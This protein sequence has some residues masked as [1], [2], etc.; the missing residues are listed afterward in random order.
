M[1]TILNIDHKFI[2]IPV[3][4]AT[5]ALA[6]YST[7]RLWAIKRKQKKENV[8]ETAKQLND[9]LLLHYGSAS[10]AMKWDFG[11]KSDLDF[12]KRCA[13]LC[14]KYWKAKASLSM[15]IIELMQI[16]RQSMNT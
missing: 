14:V 7:G 6:I 4:A 2:A 3:V 13:D 9:Y 12:P 11:P 1:P 10:E 8:Y 5:A 15:L 16:S